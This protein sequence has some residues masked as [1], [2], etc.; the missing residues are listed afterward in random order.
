MNSKNTSHFFKKY[1]KIFGGKD[2]PITESLIPFGLECGNG[3]YWLIDQLCQSIQSHVDNIEE[4]AKIRNSARLTG[5]VLGPPEETD[6]Q[7]VAEQVK[8]KFG[9]LRFYVEKADDEVYGMIELAEHMSYSICER[10]G[11]N[12]ASPNSDGWIRT[13]CPKCRKAREAGER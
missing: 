12:N 13:L 3:W 9:G 1:P 8:E 5:S 2:K 7:V 11:S 4:S 10:C 6:R